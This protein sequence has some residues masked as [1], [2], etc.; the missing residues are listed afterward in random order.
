MVDGHTLFDYNVGLNDIVQILV[1]KALP[2]VSAEAKESQK[3]ELNGTTNDEREDEKVGERQN[4]Y[5][6]GDE[7]CIYCLN[8]DDLNILFRI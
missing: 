3:D 4:Q 2:I 7:Y 5:V 1:Q 6:D 8:I